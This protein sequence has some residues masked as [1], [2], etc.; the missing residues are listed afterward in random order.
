MEYTFF[1]TIVAYL[2]ALAMANPDDGF[3][4]F[5]QA[6]GYFCSLYDLFDMLLF[7]VCAAVGGTFGALFNHIVEELN[8]MR[9]HHP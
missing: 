1:A 6:T 5:K 8:H 4:K 7:V 9:A 2:V 3:T